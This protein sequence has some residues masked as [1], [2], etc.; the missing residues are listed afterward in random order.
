[1]KEI[2]VDNLRVGMVLAQS[3]YKDDKLMLSEGIELNY[4][5]IEAISQLEKKYVKIKKSSFEF[6]F[7]DDRTNIY[8]RTV[9]NFKSISYS[10]TI[11]DVRI[12]DK[13]EK[14]VKLILKDVETKDKIKNA[15]WQVYSSDYLTYEHSVKVSMLCGYMGSVLGFSEDDT[16]YL[17]LAG[18]LHGIGKVNIPNSILHKPDLLSYGEKQVIKTYPTLG[19]IILKMTKEIPDIVLKAVLHHKERID[20]LGYPSGLRGDDIP[21]FSRIISIADVFDALISNKSYRK[22]ENP[23]KAIQIIAQER[24]ISLDKRLADI[25]LKNIKNCYVGQRVIFKNG[26][27][28]IIHSF[29]DKNKHLPIV[30]SIDKLIDLNENLDL[31]IDAILIDLD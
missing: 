15:L 12:Y 11:G 5:Y 18:L 24:G 1:M 21:E 10:Y 8:K 30:K 13:I 23:C 20:G 14:T 9:E 19:Y 27:I 26:D 17:S 29:S 7:S 25:F 4:R 28:G 6:D 22:K 16:Y 2:S 3:I 31:E